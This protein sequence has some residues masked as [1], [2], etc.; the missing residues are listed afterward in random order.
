MATVC[1]LLE[2][3][4]SESRGWPC[5]SAPVSAVAEKNFVFLRFQASFVTLRHWSCCGSIDD[6]FERLVR[7]RPNGCASKGLQPTARDYFW[8]SGDA[9]E[10]RVICT[11]NL[12]RGKVVAFGAKKCLTAFCHF[13]LQR[14]HQLSR[15]AIFARF[16]RICISKQKPSISLRLRIRRVIERA[17]F[18]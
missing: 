2:G 18:R 11:V 9:R 8:W 15:A 6:I 10:I 13:P 12:Y 4:M 17:D 7:K 3:M 14:N 1:P 5:L 16:R